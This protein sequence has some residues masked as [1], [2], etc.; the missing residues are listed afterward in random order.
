MKIVKVKLT[1][2]YSMIYH[3]VI[4]FIVLLIGKAYLI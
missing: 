3:K 1:I 4:I 2:A